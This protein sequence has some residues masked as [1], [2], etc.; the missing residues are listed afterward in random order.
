MMNICYLTAVSEG[1]EFRRSF[2]R[3][4][5][6]GVTHE[7]AIKL[8]MEEGLDATGRAAFKGAHSLTQ[9]TN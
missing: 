1:Q 3:W 4:L 2:A 9:S 7:V 6:L 8:F 5:W